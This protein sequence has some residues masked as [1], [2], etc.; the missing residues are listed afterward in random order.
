MRF[1][2]SGPFFRNPAANLLTIISIAPTFLSSRIAAA[3]II[4]NTLTNTSSATNQCLTPITNNGAGYRLAWGVDLVLAEATAGADTTTGQQEQPIVSSNWT[5]PC[6]CATWCAGLTLCNYFTWDN[7]T[8]VCTKREWL[9]SSAKLDWASLLLPSPEVTLTGLAGMNGAF[10]LALPVKVPPVNMSNFYDCSVQCM[11]LPDCLWAAWNDETNTCQLNAGVAKHQGFALGVVAM[12][13]SQLDLPTASGPAAGTVNP[14]TTSIVSSGPAPTNPA[15]AGSDDGPNGGSGSSAVVAGAGDHHGENG[16]AAIIGAVAAVLAVLCLIT[17]LFLLR[18]HR[19][20]T[21]EANVQML[22]PKVTVT[23]PPLTSPQSYE[24]HSVS[25]PAAT[26]TVTATTVGSRSRT[27]HLS[28]LTT[29]GVSSAS[30]SRGRG[31]SDLES[32]TPSSPTS[33]TSATP[34]ASTPYLPFDSSPTSQTFPSLP[35]PPRRRTVTH[36]PLPPAYV[37]APDATP[38]SPGTEFYASQDQLPTVADDLAVKRGD[39]V[40]VQERTG[41]GADLGE[42]REGM[43]YVAN[44]TRGGKGFVPRGFLV[45]KEQGKIPVS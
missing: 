10:P 14:P 36:Q 29:S 35:P 7:Q 41:D 6:A 2:S 4:P 39:H 38:P 17:A 33:A 21:R 44:L 31:R 11:L 16:T 22:S 43:L 30:T 40:M 34:F 45:D 28:F 27:S 3:A 20:R 8:N 13:L 18:R 15:T 1:R 25:Q 24:L 19:R 23:S 26:R 32:Y 37:A 12:G 42:D 9:E 5:T